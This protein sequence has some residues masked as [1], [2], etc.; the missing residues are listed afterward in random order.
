MSISTVWQGPNGL[1]Q[2]GQCP[3][4]GI[5]A[6]E[7]DVFLVKEYSH[8]KDIIDHCSATVKK[9]QVQGLKFLFAS[10]RLHQLALLH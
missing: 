2:C 1:N 6:I 5:S 10:K 7:S 3:H 8:Q 9:E 4:I